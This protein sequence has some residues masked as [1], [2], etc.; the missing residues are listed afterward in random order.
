MATIGSTS[1][2]GEVRSPTRVANDKGRG[3]KR[4]P[5]DRAAGDD[6]AWAV[7]QPR[8][9]RACGPPGARLHRQAA[10]Q[11]EVV[12][13]GMGLLHHLPVAH[14]GDNSLLRQHSIGSAPDLPENLGLFGHR[15]AASSGDPE[16]RDCTPTPLA[17]DLPTFHGR[18]APR[19]SRRIVEIVQPWRT[20]IGAVQP[21]SDSAS[22]CSASICSIALHRRH[23]PCRNGGA[24]RHA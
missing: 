2:E 10:D 24:T 14:V 17:S 1:D 22:N 18:K 3:P 20:I 23:D 11:S 13:R 21:L 9:C 7:R 8:K 15:P 4:H 16:T 19:G 6:L 12:E 5:A